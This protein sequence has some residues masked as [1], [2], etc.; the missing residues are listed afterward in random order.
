MKKS[1]DKQFIEEGIDEQFMEE[2]MKEAEKIRQRLLENGYG[3]VLGAI[4]GTPKKEEKAC[5][6]L[7]QDRLDKIVEEVK[8]ELAKEPSKPAFKLD[9]PS[10]LAKDRE[11]DYNDVRRDKK[12]KRRNDIEQVKYV[13]SEMEV[14]EYFGWDWNDGGSIECVKYYGKTKDNNMI[15]NYAEDEIIPIDD[16]FEKNCD[17]MG[18]YREDRFDSSVE[19][20]TKESLD[21]EFAQYAHP[22]AFNSECVSPKRAKEY[23]RGFLRNNPKEN[24]IFEVE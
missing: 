16:I 23:V 12:G 7:T 20:R 1:K 3:D 19:I 14:G 2:L 15:I 21:E 13:L 17:A 5:N 24:W 10:P 11:L 4:F 9:A 8:E 18:F 6:I 22:I